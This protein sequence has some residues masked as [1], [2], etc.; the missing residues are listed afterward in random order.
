MRAGGAAGGLGALGETGSYRAT[1]VRGIGGHCGALGGGRDWELLGLVGWGELGA[2]GGG[3]AEGRSLTCM[4]G[5]G[6]TS[7]DLY[8]NVI[9]CQSLPGVETR[10]RDIDILIVRENTEGEYSSLEHEVGHA[11]GHAPGGHTP[12]GPHPTGR[13][14]QRIALGTLPRPRPQPKADR[15]TPPPHGYTA[16]GTPLE[17]WPHPHTG[18]LAWARPLRDGHTPTPPR[19]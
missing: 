6:R 5:R 4:S 18:T 16:L 9:H 3:V 7:L 12:T 2:V 15:A 10:H 17:G 14:A 1:G 19:S 13:A 8:A 11:C